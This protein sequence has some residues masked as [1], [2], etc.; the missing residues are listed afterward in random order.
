MLPEKFTLPKELI[1]DV[2]DQ[3]K[4]DI[5]VA[6][7]L[8]AVLQ[9]VYYKKTGEREQFSPTWG[10][11]MWRS[12]VHGQKNMASLNPDSAIPAMIASGAVLTEDCPE[13]LENPQ[14]YEYV[15]ARPELQDKV[16]HL[17]E[18]FEKINN[19]SREARIDAVKTALYE[20]LLPI[21]AVVKERKESH[22]VPIIGWDDNKERFYVMNSWGKGIDTYKYEDL[23]RGYLIKPCKEEKEEKKNM[24][25]LLMAGHGDGDSGAIG[26]G[27]KEAEVAREIVGMLSE[28]LQLA[29]D[30]EVDVF[31]TNKNPYKH[32]K[33]NTFD[34]TMYDYV[35][36]VHLNACV[37]DEK[38]DGKT[39]GTEILVHK[40]EYGT[41]I[42]EGILKHIC[43]LGFKNRGVKRRSD[44]Q[45]MNIVSKQGVSYALL[46]TCF[47]DDFDDMELLCIKTHEVVEAIVDGLCEGYNLAKKEVAKVDKFTDIKGHWCEDDINEFA[48]RG[49]VDGRGDGTFDPDATITRAENVRMMKNHEAAIIAEVKKMLNV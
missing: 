22:C 8:T 40:S 1:P 12:D 38:G 33:S 43:A 21:V 30:I 19:G 3:K 7:A 14:A 48:E 24:R 34:F 37:D 11:V 42:E 9:I 32:L 13:L 31:D 23:K 25:M 10:A 20:N 26:C 39:T 45:N 16:I 4:C 2:R 28:R 5:C 17:V 47:I 15:M 36:E 18:G 49:I 35:F 6:M 44:L 41:S 46:E 27:Y 29:T